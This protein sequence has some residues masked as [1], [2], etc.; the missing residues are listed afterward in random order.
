MEEEEAAWEHKEAP[1]IIAVTFD[2]ASQTRR[3]VAFNSAWAGLMSL[4][5]E[6]I[7]AR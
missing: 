7:A 3:R 4:H 1:A 5:P 2:P 6:E